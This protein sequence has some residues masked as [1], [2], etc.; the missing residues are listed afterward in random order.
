VR[1]CPAPDSVTAGR[2]ADQHWFTNHGGLHCVAGCPLD[3]ADGEDTGRMTRRHVAEI[4]LTVSG[5]P[6]GGGGAGNAPA[7][8]QHPITTTCPSCKSAHLVW[9]PTVTNETGVADGQLR[10]HDVT[11][12]AVLGCEECSE[13]V[14]KVSMDS[15]PNSP[16]AG[17]RGYTQA[18]AEVMSAPVTVHSRSPT[19]R[20]PV[21]RTRP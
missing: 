9:S 3:L 1:G 12:Y 5:R 17:Q 7:A 4:A 15:A 20:G 13:T 11:S 2:I 19:S 10:V 6:T 8:H 18:P 16:D 14:L 21:C